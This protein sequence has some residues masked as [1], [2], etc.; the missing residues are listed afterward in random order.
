MYIKQLLWIAIL[1]LFAGGLY[2]WVTNDRETTP[3]QEEAAQEQESGTV[4]GTWQSVE[5]AD[6]IRVIDANGAYADLHD[7]ELISGGS[8]LT[9]TAES[10]L[11]EFPYPIEEDVTYLALLGEGDPLYFSIAEQTE[12]RLVLIFLNRGGVLEFE[13]IR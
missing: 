10:E 12:S 9:F 4:T 7:G 6:F 8:W 5:D 11:A 2:L 13:R 1:I 3:T